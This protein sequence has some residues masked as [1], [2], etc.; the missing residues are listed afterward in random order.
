[1]I[2][3]P[4][5]SPS[6]LTST[7]SS[8]TQQSSPS[9]AWGAWKRIDSQSPMSAYRA[10]DIGM[11]SPLITSS[12][13]ALAPHESSG[14]ASPLM[15]PSPL[16]H[17]SAFAAPMHPSG[18]PQL[19]HT[20]VHRRALSWSAKSPYLRMRTDVHAAA[21]SLYQCLPS[22][23]TRGAT[24]VVPAHDWL[25]TSKEVR[26]PMLLSSGAAPHDACSMAGEVTLHEYAHVGAPIVVGQSSPDVSGCDHPNISPVANLPLASRSA[27]PI[28]SSY[29]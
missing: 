6:A 5:F 26:A 22:S 13:L 21:G 2:L 23:L 10:S 17:S 20:H 16:T 11:T 8:P 4:N 3:G 7:L 12:T 28:I 24:P 25:D 18:A 29:E 19:L 14:D 9:L 27:T 1:M 15:H